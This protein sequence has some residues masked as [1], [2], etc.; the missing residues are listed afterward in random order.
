MVFRTTLHETCIELRR[1][2]EHPKLLPNNAGPT[3]E[4]TK[5]GL[6]DLF[7]LAKLE[8]KMEVGPQTAISTLR[9]YI[10]ACYDEDRTTWQQFLHSQAPGS[11][12]TKGVLPP[13]GCT[14]M[15]PAACQFLMDYKEFEYEAC[16]KSLAEVRISP[17]VPLTRF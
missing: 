17:L 9:K 11:G 5:R 15:I 8:Q 2:L 14:Q 7:D 4:L 10:L 13:Y 16:S 3:L 12:F 1:L 6:Q